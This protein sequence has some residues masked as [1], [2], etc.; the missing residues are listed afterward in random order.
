MKQ[1]LIATLCAAFALT[2]AAQAQGVPPS[3]AEPYRA[4]Q[5]A[6][7]AEAFDEA[8]DAAIEAWQAAVAADLDT[9]TRAALASNAFVALDAAQDWDVLASTALN[10]AFD[11]HAS[12]DT[13]SAVL[14]IVAGRRA[15]YAVRDWVSEDLLVRQGGVFFEEIQLESQGLLSALLSAQAPE[16]LSADVFAEQWDGIDGSDIDPRRVA[17]LALEHLHSAEGM[18]HQEEFEFAVEALGHVAGAAPDDPRLTD[19]IFVF[20][21]RALNGLEIRGDAQ[22]AFP[23][24]LRPAW[25]AYMARYAVP[26][27][28]ENEPQFPTRE[29]ERGNSDAVVRTAYRVPSAGGPVSL[30]DDSRPRGRTFRFQRAS[31]AVWEDQPVRPQCDP[32]APDRTVEIMHLYAIVD[33]SPPGPGGRFIVSAHVLVTQIPVE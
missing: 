30:V 10:L 23:E 18:S 12:G 14:V 29:V 5:A 32:A 20:A 28:V 24:H 4:Y 26:E 31:R 21:A 2:G 7:E 16:A 22:D 9:E 15:A 11:I 19:P 25:C 1:F 3:V 13:E 6:M 8:A 17:N 33:H 27:T